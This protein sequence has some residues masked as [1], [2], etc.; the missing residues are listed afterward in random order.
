ML[1]KVSI[2]NHLVRRPIFLSSYAVSDLSFVETLCQSVYSTS[3]SASVGEIASMHGVLFFV[4]KEFIAM[5]DQLCQ[6]FNLA[7]YLELCEDNFV[8]AMETYEVLAVPSF[9]NIL[10]LTMGVNKYSQFFHLINKLTEISDAEGSGRSKTLFI[11]EARLCRC[12][13][14]PIAWLSP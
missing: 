2:L 14:L 9:E 4:L 3:K 7:T 8:A 6:K 5:E 1:T 10:A 11:L 12:H 13:P